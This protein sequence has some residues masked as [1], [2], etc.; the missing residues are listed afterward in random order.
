MTRTDRLLLVLLAPAVFLAPVNSP[1]AGATQQ[2]VFI[3]DLGQGAGRQCQDDVIPAVHF[4]GGEGVFMLGNG[5][6]H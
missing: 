3:R 5:H 4:L 1:A 2:N 6:F